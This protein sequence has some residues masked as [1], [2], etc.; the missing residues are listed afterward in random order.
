MVAGWNLIALKDKLVQARLSFQQKDSSKEQVAIVEYDAATDLSRKIWEEFAYDAR[1]FDLTE[2]VKQHKAS[3]IAYSQLL[4]VLGT[5]IGLSVQ[6]LDVK[7]TRTGELPPGMAHMAGAV[8]L[9]DGKVLMVDPMIRFVSKPFV[10]QEQFARVGRYWQLIDRTNPLAI[11]AVIR[12]FERDAL[13]ACL[14]NNRGFAANGVG[15][16]ADA[17]ACCTKAIELEPGI[18]ETHTIRGRA[19][20][21]VGQFDKAV[22]DFTKAIEIDPKHATA[23]FNRG[24]AYARLGKNEDARNDLRTAVKMQPILERNVKAVSEEL[25]L[26]L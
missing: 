4:I 2:V 19:Y 18:A 25:K 12:V 26:P 1:V 10:F 15:R 7:E 6:A 3:C 8:A 9:S 11:H 20:S 22:E 5:P 13:V 21:G 17:I 23:Y 16:Y 14:Y 24:V